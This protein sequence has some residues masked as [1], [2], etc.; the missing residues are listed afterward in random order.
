MNW[1]WPRHLQSDD[2]VWVRVVR[3]IHWCVLGFAAF[4]LIVTFVSLYE[5]GD[6]ELISYVAMACFWVAL[7]MLARG[8]RYI[9]VRE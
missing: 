7:A 8:F 1:L 3:V 6:A 5:A 9:L 2:R 4:G